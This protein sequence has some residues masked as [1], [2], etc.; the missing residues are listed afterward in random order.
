MEIIITT[1][2]IAEIA[3]GSRTSANAVLVTPQSVA[4]AQQK[5][6]RPAL[7]EEM[8]DAV[9]RGEYPDFVSE[10]LKLPLAL[11]TK[12]IILHSAD[13]VVGAMGVSRQNNPN[14]SP[15]SSREYG[16]ALRH[17]RSDAMVHL[18][19][20]MEH[21]AAN[22]NKYPHYNPAQSRFTEVSIQG[23]VVL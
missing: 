16:L 9:L 15:L 17:L 1:G 22:R 3:F 5:Y 14:A 12:S 4:T 10:F 21:L 20:A 18:G 6:I 11:L 8:F 13:Y 2:D 23:G 19:G 7:G